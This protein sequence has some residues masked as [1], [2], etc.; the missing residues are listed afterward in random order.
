MVTG[1]WRRHYNRP[2]AWW[3]EPGEDVTTGLKLGDWHLEKTL[4]QAYS[5]VAGT[6]GRRYN[7]PTAWWLTPADVTTGL[8]PSDWH[9]E[10][11]Q[12]TYRLVTGTRRRRYNRP[13]AWWLAAKQ[14]LQ[15]AY[16][17]VTGSRA[18][19]T[20][21]LQLGDWHQSR[22]NNYPKAWLGDGD[23][24]CGEPSDQTQTDHHNNDGLKKKSWERI[25]YSNLANSGTCSKTNVAETIERQDHDHLDNCTC[26]HSEHQ[27]ADETY[28]LT[29]HSILSAG[30]PVPGMTL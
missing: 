18:D 19:A 16:S 4:Q 9:L 13:T 14:T 7:R 24:G 12:Q 1:T 27:G 3:L 2:T 23:E 11:L 8:Q 20:T 26:Y 10:M 15:Q 25:K 30:Q 29:I 17:L 5:L 21:G 22:R 6:W 28:Y